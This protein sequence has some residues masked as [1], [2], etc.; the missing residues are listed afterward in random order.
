MG[1]GLVSVST[2][3]TMFERSRRILWLISRTAFSPGSNTT[4]AL[5][6][7]CSPTS[8]SLPSGVIRADMHV[9]KSIAANALSN[10]NE[11][12]A[13]MGKV[14]NLVASATNRPNRASSKRD[15]SNGQP[16]LTARPV[17]GFSPTGL[18]VT[19][20]ASRNALSTL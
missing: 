4:C 9:S 1:V 11:G 8:N 3:A 16:A 12:A 17:G 14:A 2:P 15:T 6:I 5:P 18:P 20:P 13:T 10:A 7:T 19:N